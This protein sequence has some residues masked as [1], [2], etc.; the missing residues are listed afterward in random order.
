MLL[1][2]NGHKSYRSLAFQDL[3]EENKIIT[4]YMPP[5]SSHILQL[6]SIRC[7]TPLKRVY[8]KE[9]RV[10]VIDYVSQ[11]DKKTFITS[12]AKVFKPAFLKINI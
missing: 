3:Y 4:L 2:I 1:I 6:L 8:S 12:F 9:I 10:L 11:I 7:F 5:H